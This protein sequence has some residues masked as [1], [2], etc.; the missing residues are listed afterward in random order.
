MSGVSPTRSTIDGVTLALMVGMPISA[1]KKTTLT[2]SAPSVALVLLCAFCGPGVLSVTQNAARLPS[3]APPPDE[4]RS[5]IAGCHQTCR[6]LQAPRLCTRGSFRGPL[7]VDCVAAA[8][9]QGRRHH[10]RALPR[11]VPGSRA[12]T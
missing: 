10:L 1:R 12:D 11:S 6:A 7:H 4:M 9:D 8:V 5:Q 3:R 2:A